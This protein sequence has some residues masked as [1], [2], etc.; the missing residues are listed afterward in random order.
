MKKILFTLVCLVGFSCLGFGQWEKISPKLFEGYQ[1]LYV[2]GDLSQSQNLAAY[3]IGSY[4]NERIYYT[5]DKGLNWKIM[6]TPGEG[7]SLNGNNRFAFNK[8][9]FFILNYGVENDRVVVYRTKDYGLS[10]TTDSVVASKPPTNGFLYP[11]FFY[12]GDKLCISTIGWPGYGIYNQ[13][14]LKNSS[15]IAYKQKAEKSINFIATKSTNRYWQIDAFLKQI[16]IRDFSTDLTLATVNLPKN[17]NTHYVQDSIIFLAN[18]KI[19]DTIY[20]SRNLG[21]T[22]IKNNFSDFKK[23]NFD[24]KINKGSI[25]ICNYTKI[26][27]TKNYGQSWLSLSDDIIMDYDSVLQ[28]RDFIVTD[29]LLAIKNNYNLY[30]KGKNDSKW[31]YANNTYSGF[32]IIKADDATL[33]GINAHSIY[34][35]KDKGKTWI[36]PHKYDFKDLNILDIKGVLYVYVSSGKVYKSVNYGKSWEIDP[37][38]P[39]FQSTIVKGDTIVINNNSKI[40]Y[41]LKAPYN[42]WD[43]IV[44]GNNSKNLLHF[45]DGITTISADKIV[46][47]QYTLAVE[48]YKLD[49]TQLESVLNDKRIYKYYSNK[50]KIWI[51]NDTFSIRFT[52]DLGKNWISYS[53][54][55]GIGFYEMHVF[56]NSLIL[57]TGTKVV[58]GKLNNNTGGIYKSDDDG[59]SWLFYSEGINVNNA[60][61]TPNLTVID[62][63]IY[64]NDVYS[65]LWWTG[66][67]NLNLKSVSGNVYL[68]SNKNGIKD[69]NEKSLLGAIVYATKS[70]GYTVTDSAGNYSFW[71]DLQGIDTLKAVYDSRSAVSVLP[72][73]HLVSGSDTAKNFGVFISAIN[74]LRVTI[75]AITPPRSGF[76]NTYQINYKNIGSTTANGSVSMTYN[77]KQSFVEATTAPT[78]NTNQTLVWNYTNLQP[79]ESRVIN[80]TL[81]TAVDAPIRTAITHVATI[82]PLSIDTF[83][84]DNVDSLVLTVV[85]SYDPNDKQVTYNNS[86]SAPAVIDN[87]TELTYTIRFQNT[88]NYPADFVKVTDTLSDKLDV[89]TLR[90]IAA[91][92]KYD[93]SLKNK[94]VLAFDFNPIFLPD[95]TSNEKDSHGFIKFAIKPKKTLTKEEVIKN[96]G[97][98]FF[99]Y[100]P[101][102]ITNTV[103]T[104]NQK[105]NSLFTPSVSEPLSI[106]PNPTTGFLTVKM[107]KYLGKEIAISIYSIDGKLMISKHQTAQSENTIN[108]ETLQEGLYILQI[109]V[110]EDVM[111]GKFSVQK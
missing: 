43:T 93:V 5:V 58:N 82:D 57:N 71:L 92:H 9:G 91:S 1:D 27:E 72:T 22:W 39:D 81:K 24:V 89:S 49:K 15:W 18:A 8:D 80:L 64:A 109:K 30:L 66:S 106:Y 38:F 26:F 59:K 63:F 111:M 32:K 90:I 110:G 102:I 31:Q 67:K 47:N 53:L 14:T 11:T 45:E 78:S 83:K 36:N 69:G 7:G 65:G 101:A 84:T 99:D 42:K 16:T 70:G 40:L 100:N 19:D 97:Y 96:T 12:E 33:V 44:G 75:T 56:G 46:N 13:Y 107:D 54:P 37:T 62:S 98:I 95:S 108:G 86:K 55:K 74:D 68:D 60:P 10:W 61:F 85:G 2:L 34:T 88:G 23:D 76:T 105:A 20:V 25:F 21:K 41:S 94:N 3:L 50:N 35:S 79:N 52:N 6:R 73:Y 87:T 4:G 29:S 103:E 28:L 51:R 17:F 48:R 104:A 77:A